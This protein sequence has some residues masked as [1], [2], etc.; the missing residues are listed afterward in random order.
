MKM[1]LSLLCGNLLLFAVAPVHADQADPRLDMLF[2]ELRAGSEVDHKATIARIETIW[3]DSA[4]DTIDVLF[5]RA[6]SSDSQD[7]SDVAEALLDMII[8]MSPHFAE[9][10]A[11]RG[12]LRL[13][14]QN[15]KGAIEDFSR[16]ID[17][18]PRQFNVRIALADIL[19]A[20]DAKQDAY[21]MLQ[22]AL[23]WNPHDDYARRRAR[24]LRQEIDGQEI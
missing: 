24:R 19:L 15:Q 2:E 13:K 20:N 22:K 17:L 1:L 14:Q 16:A 12:S 4:S 9:A 11:F 6:V 3:A 18:E 5:A 7:E 23:E 8:G 10:Y 21:D